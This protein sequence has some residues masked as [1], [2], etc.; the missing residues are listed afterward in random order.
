MDATG[1]P[2]RWVT[3]PIQGWNQGYFSINSG[4]TQVL[5][6]LGDDAATTLEAF[7]RGV[8]GLSPDQPIPQIGWNSVLAHLAERAVDPSYGGMPTSLEIPDANELEVE[9]THY[10]AWRLTRLPYLTARR[11][12]V[13]TR[14]DDSA[15]EDDTG[16]LTR[17]Q[18]EGAR[19]RQAHT[20]E[21]SDRFGGSGGGSFLGFNLSA[22]AESTQTNRDETDAE[23]TGNV[24]DRRRTERMDET[25]RTR[26]VDDTEESEAR[27][28]YADW[29]LVRISSFAVQ[30]LKPSTKVLQEIRSDGQGRMIAPRPVWLKS[31]DHAEQV[32]EKRGDSCRKEDLPSSRSQ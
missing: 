24:E 11:S 17:T 16:E 4:T 8:E 32:L 9:V 26:G 28:A 25:S 21:T 23:R 7:I 19:Y 18:S 20:S 30:G 2:T 10:D 3:V 22:N 5:P 14:R 27:T 31:L 12:V 13:T 6:R 29:E 1:T 15:R